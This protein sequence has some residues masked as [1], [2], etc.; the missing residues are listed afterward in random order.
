MANDRV[1]AMPS[2]LYESKASFLKRLAEFYPNFTSND[3]NQLSLP[4]PAP[5]DSPM[6]EVQEFQVGLTVWA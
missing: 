5:Q 3:T 2:L 4:I 1:G 6:K